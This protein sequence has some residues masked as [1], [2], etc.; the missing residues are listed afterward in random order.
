MSFKSKMLA[1]AATLT[2]VG[3]AAGVL[4]SGP[5]NAATPSCGHRCVNLFSKKFSDV[6]TTKPGFV[7]DVFRQG[8]RVGQ[9]IIMFQSSNADPAEDFTVSLQG[10]T[11]DFVQAGL[12]SPALDLHYATDAAWEFEYSPN[13][14]DSGLCVGISSAPINNAPVSLQPCGVSAKTV[15]ITDS[16]NVQRGGLFTFPFVPLINAAGTNFSHPFVL[17]YPPNGNPNDKPRPQLVT[18]NLHQF[19][20]GQVY[21]N[22]QWS[23]FFGVLR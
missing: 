10:T 14:V 11:D 22:Q 21:D 16:E 18:Q 15:W 17:T 13:G 12:V 7:L 3:G 9:P 1:A 2:L 4:A 8:A 6:L 5:A 23:A 20:R 19:S